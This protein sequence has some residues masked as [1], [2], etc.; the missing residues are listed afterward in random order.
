MI[1]FEQNVSFVN[2]N[3]NNYYNKNTDYLSLKSMMKNKILRILAAL[4]FVNF[5]IKA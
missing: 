5:V 2:L 3:Q 1:L 4:I